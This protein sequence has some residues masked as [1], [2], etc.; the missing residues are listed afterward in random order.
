MQSN[1]LDSHDVRALIRA[2]RAKTLTNVTGHR[3]FPLVVARPHTVWHHEM[4]WL[5]NAS[6]CY[7]ALVALIH[8]RAER[9]STWCTC[10]ADKPMHNLDQEALF[11][12]GLL[13]I[14][15]ISLEVASFLLVSAHSVSNSD[16]YGDLNEAASSGGCGWPCP[17]VSARL[18]QLEEEVLNHDI[19]DVRRLLGV[20]VEYRD[21]A[22][23]E[24]GLGFEYVLDATKYQLEEF[25]GIPPCL[26]S[27]IVKRGQVEL[28]TH[29]QRERESL[30]GAANPKAAEI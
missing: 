25:F 2:E 10:I 27:S 28:N 24:A 20:N 19:F 8:E 17:D 1:P 16:I 5:P 29:I 15:A 6:I 12:S 9:S 30:C 18:H 13:E 11:L 23:E 21:L 22:L 7:T 26:A 3:M 4:L 14:D